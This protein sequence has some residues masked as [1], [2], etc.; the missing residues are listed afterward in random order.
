[1][2]QKMPIEN[3]NSINPKV[4]WKRNVISTNTNMKL[5]LKLEKFLSLCRNQSCQQLDNSSTY[6]AIPL[7]YH[8]GMASSMPF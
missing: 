8:S 5:L 7:A 2:Q 6:N 4:A 3:I 1:M